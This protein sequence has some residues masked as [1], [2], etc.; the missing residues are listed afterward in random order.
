M[1]LNTQAIHDA[2][3]SQIL[4]ITGKPANAWD[5]TSTAYPA[6]TVLPG[7]PYVTY[8]NTPTMVSMNLQVEVATN[9][10][11]KESAQIALSRFVNAGTGETTSILDALENV[12]SLTPTLGGVVENINVVDVSIFTRTSPDGANQ[13]HVALFN[14]QVLARRA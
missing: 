5:T 1:A 14:I 11:E 6:I 7:T 12:T 13:E 10:M 9:A 3:A 2:L 8:H 4:T